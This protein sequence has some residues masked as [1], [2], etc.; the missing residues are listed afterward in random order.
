[1]AFSEP[2]EGRAGGR[3]RVVAPPTSG[4]TAAQEAQFDGP[5][6]TAS[7]EPEPE[8]ASQGSGGLSGRLRGADAEVTMSERDRWI[9]EQRPP[10]WS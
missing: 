1:M 6:C 7:A 8:A 4:R 10:H 3:R 2:R 9:V 5:D